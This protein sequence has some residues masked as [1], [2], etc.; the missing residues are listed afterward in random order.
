MGLED[1]CEFR[2]PCDPTYA[3][4]DDDPVWRDGVFEADGTRRV[5]R[6]R[7]NGDCTFLGALG[8][9]LPPLVRPLVCRLFPFQYTA[10]GLSETLDSHCPRELLLSGEPILDAL[11]MSAAEAEACRAQLYQEIRS[12]RRGPARAKEK[13]RA[14]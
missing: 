8:C 10:D 12:E 5:I 6:Q 11:R 2:G 13:P 14:A 3:D 1:F 7:A 9:V 4:Q